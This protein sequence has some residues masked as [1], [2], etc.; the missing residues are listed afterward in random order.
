MRQES[1][2]AFRYGW[3]GWCI[4]LGLG[5]GVE[6]IFFQSLTCVH[7]RLVSDTCGLVWFG[8]VNR[9]VTASRFMH[10]TGHTCAKTFGF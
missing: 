7:V 5:S 9:P 2:A 4:G 8:L 1:T 6:F 10:V 3:C